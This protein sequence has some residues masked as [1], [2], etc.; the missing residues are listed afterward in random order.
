MKLNRIFSLITLSLV[1]TAGLD[2]D[3]KR[4]ARTDRVRIAAELELG[5]EEL[6][7]SI[8]SKFQTRGERKRLQVEAAGFAVGDVFTASIKIGAKSY[9]LG[10]MTA[11]LNE[12]GIVEA[13]LDFREDSWLVGL[14]M[15]IPAGSEVSVVKGNMVNVLVL[16]A[17]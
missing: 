4:A 15:D 13:E 14:P 2:S 16:Q 11:E 1:L 17:K 8:Q 9:L 12:E 5:T 10:D 7:Q 6:P 3:A